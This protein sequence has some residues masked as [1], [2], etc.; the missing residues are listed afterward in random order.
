MKDDIER[1]KLRVSKAFIERQKCMQFLMRSAGNENLVYRKKFNI[2]NEKYWILQEKLDYFESEFI[3]ADDEIEIKRLGNELCN[4][5]NIYL[6]KNKLKVG[7]IDYRGYHD[8]VISG[9]VGYVIDYRYRGNNYAYKAL[10]L[11]SNYLYDNNIPDFYISVFHDNIPSIK[12]I[13]KYGGGMII[14]EDDKITTYECETRKKEN[15]YK[16]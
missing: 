12:T 14:K 8:S 9:D 10:C 11:F 5:Y 1:L 2:L 6:K 13:H 16:R 3:A 4:M 15:K 7:H